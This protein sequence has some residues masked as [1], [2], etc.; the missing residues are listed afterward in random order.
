MTEAEVK[1]VHMKATRW[2]EVRIGEL[3]G[4]ATQGDR[5][6][7]KPELVSAV[8]SLGTHERVQFRDM[9]ENKDVVEECLE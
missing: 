6:D 5:S 3:L 7:L 2:C 4:P 9:A 8:T 1:E